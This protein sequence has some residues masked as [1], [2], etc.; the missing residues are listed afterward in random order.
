[1]QIHSWFWTYKL[2]ISTAFAVTKGLGKKTKKQLTL[3]RILRS[4]AH[5]EDCVYSINIAYLCLI[6]EKVV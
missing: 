2:G 5:T 4:L 6:F 3:T 1:M